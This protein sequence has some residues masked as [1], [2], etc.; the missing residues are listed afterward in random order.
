MLCTQLQTLYLF[1]SNSP[2]LPHTQQSH[3]LIVFHS[4]CIHESKEQISR[5]VSQNYTGWNTIVIRTYSFALGMTWMRVVV[6]GSRNE[7][8]GCDPP[9]LPVLSMWEWTS[10]IETIGEITQRNVGNGQ[11]QSLISDYLYLWYCLRGV[12]RFVLDTAL[13]LP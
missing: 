2:Q 11:Y 10:W 5:T 12:Q 6:S 9:F 8:N 7:G 13:F 4:S 1:T 3:K